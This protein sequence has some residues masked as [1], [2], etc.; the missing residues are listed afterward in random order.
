M[1]GQSD[2]GP[3]IRIW[4]GRLISLLPIED[5]RDP[6][7]FTKHTNRRDFQVLVNH[8]I[9][10]TKDEWLI[11]ELWLHRAQQRS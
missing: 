3:E 7:A 9:D 1:N 2:A 6:L 10:R 11:P 8:R 4:E 5:Q